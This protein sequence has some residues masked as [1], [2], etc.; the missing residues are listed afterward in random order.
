MSLE[1]EFDALSKRYNVL[2]DELSQC[3]LQRLAVAHE[4]HSKGTEVQTPTTHW[5]ETN[6]ALHTANEQLQLKSQEVEIANSALKKVNSQLAS[7]V[8]DRILAEERLKGEQKKLRTIIESEPAWVNICDATGTILE[9]NPAG[10][11]IMEADS[12]EQLIGSKL[13]DFV[14]RDYAQRL[15]HLRANLNP[16]EPGRLELEINTLK[17]A[18][19]WVEI[20][21]VAVLDHNQE[22]LIISI[23]W[24]HTERKQ[25]QH[26]AMQRQIEL[27]Q[28]MRLNTLGEMA[29]G[30][31]HEL[32]QPLSAISNFI[33][34]CERR[35]RDG[36]CNRE[37][38]LKTLHAASQQAKRAGTIVN[39]V[40]HFVKHND[41]QHA[42]VGI[43][44]L[45]RGAVDLMR[46]T[47]ELDQ[48]KLDLSLTEGLPLVDANEVQIEQVLINLVRN[49]IE[50]MK[51]AKTPAPG[52]IISSIYGHDGTVMVQVEDNGPGLPDPKT[53]NIFKPF[54]TT[55][56]TGMGM[57]LSISHSIIETHAGKLEGKNSPQNG[58]VLYFTLPIVRTLTNV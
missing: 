24:D 12:D 51:H 47:G 31:A 30:L 41:F 14:H 21:A 56:T 46:V 35:L 32:N 58:A 55:K 37:E 5:Q 20:S 18:I 10:L 26:E 43:N 17:G 52:I 7:E 44:T 28:V 57:G 34:G 53:T 29:S 13:D 22:P 49:S 25:A 48:V 54:I 39:Q 16:G 2:K 9:V 15:Q 42:D 1:T 33:S 23:V 40:K 3:H 27:A 4:L 38:L 50:A 19:R 36:G 11:T 45:I 8:D 6:K